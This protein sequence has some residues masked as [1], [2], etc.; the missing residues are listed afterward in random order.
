MGNIEGGEA[1]DWFY[2]DKAA[3]MHRR[4]FRSRMVPMVSHGSIARRIFA[5]GGPMH[6]M[7]GR[8]ASKRLADRM[9]T[10]IEA[11]PLHGTRLPGRRQ[12]QQ[13]TNVFPDP[14]SSESAYPWYSNR[15]RDDVM[16]RVWIEAMLTYYADPAHNPVSSVYGG[17]MIDLD[18]SNVWAWDARPLPTFPL[19]TDWGDAPNW[20][21]GHWLN[22]RLGLLRLPRKQYVRFSTMQVFSDYAIEPIRPSSMAS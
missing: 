19:D 18:R 11:R 5:T 22:G 12:R 3:A 4:D 16:G 10:T 6:T 17:R 20:E 1:Y 21:T 2:A 9:D 7:T 8:A 14:K 13:S 15:G